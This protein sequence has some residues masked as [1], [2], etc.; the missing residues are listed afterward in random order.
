MSLRQSHVIIQVIAEIQGV[1][2]LVELHDQT[3]DSVPA[4]WRHLTHDV[5]D[6]PGVL[7]PIK[8]NLEI[9]AQLGISRDT[10]QGPHDLGSISTESSDLILD[11]ILVKQEA[12]IG[13]RI[14]EYRSRERHDHD[15][16]VIY[17]YARVCV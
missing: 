10:P 14:S 9:A 13:Q 11:S 16:Y 4:V 15:R 8:P 7:L 6:V 3:S 1:R 2:D 5:H 12:S 17:R